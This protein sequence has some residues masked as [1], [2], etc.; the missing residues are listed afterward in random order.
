MELGFLLSTN[1]IHRRRHERLFTLYTENF[2]SVQMDNS[3]SHDS[4]AR[5]GKKGWIIGGTVDFRLKSTF[6]LEII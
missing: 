1:S 5:I 3:S 4:S 6:V 2:E